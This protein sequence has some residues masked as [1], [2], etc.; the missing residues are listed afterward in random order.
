MGGRVRLC[1][2]IATI[3]CDEGT[4][5]TDRNRQL[6][7]VINACIDAVH[8]QRV[9]GDVEVQPANNISG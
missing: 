5:P 8:R 4:R 7:V 2:G 6:G 3:R 9:A 1:R